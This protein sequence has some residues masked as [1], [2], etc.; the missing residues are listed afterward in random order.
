MMKLV[1]GLLITTSNG[2]NMRG[3]GRSKC[4]FP[5][6]KYKLVEDRSVQRDDFSRVQCDVG[7]HLN[8]IKKKRL[9]VRCNYKGKPTID[10][11][12][13]CVPIAC[14]KTNLAANVNPRFVKMNDLP[15]DTYG[16]D[17]K[18]PKVRCMYSSEEVELKCNRNNKLALM[19][20]YREKG[21]EVCKKKIDKDPCTYDTDG[22]SVPQHN[23][24]RYG[25]CIRPASFSSYT[26]KC[27]FSHE[28]K[29]IY[30]DWERTQKWIEGQRSVDSRYIAKSFKQCSEC[31]CPTKDE[32]K[33]KLTEAKNQGHIKIEKK[34]KKTQI[35]LKWER[36]EKEVVKEYSWIAKKFGGKKDIVKIVKI[37]ETLLKFR[38]DR[39]K[40]NKFSRDF[41][42][43]TSRKREIKEMVNKCPLVNNVRRCGR[44]EVRGWNE[45][46]VR[47]EIVYKYSEQLEVTVGKM[48]KGKLEAVHDK[49]DFSYIFGI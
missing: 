25:Q 33:K 40:T 29:N 21:K 20:K 44:W 23:S 37:E 7:F 6:N 18:I 43:L 36:E 45:R 8:D 42:K 47:G 14:S 48:E 31:R 32:V 4:H 41:L 22:K 35:Q 16:F 11:P 30:F 1:L 17:E 39:S 15:D 27:T 26:F 10:P 46:N 19:A 49:P 12:E 9:E 2:L 5:K 38:I 28:E 13:G 34:N 24:E 3:R